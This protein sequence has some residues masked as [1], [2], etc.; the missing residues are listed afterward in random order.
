MSPLIPGV[1]SFFDS[2]PRVSGDEPA[3]LPRMFDALVFSPR[4]R[5]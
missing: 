3:R 4:E 5:G 1:Q 2:F